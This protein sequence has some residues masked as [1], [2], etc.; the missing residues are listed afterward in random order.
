[1]VAENKNSS[2]ESIIH[3]SSCFKIVKQ[4]IPLL[5]SSTVSTGQQTHFH[6]STPQV[7]YPNSNQ[8]AVKTYVGSTDIDAI[9]RLSNEYDVLSKIQKQR[10]KCLCGADAAA[11]T[12]SFTEDGSNK[13]D[14][15]LD[16]KFTTERSEMKSCIRGTLGRY[17]PTGRIESIYLE[18]IE[19]ISL[20]EWIVRLNKKRISTVN[21]DGEM[22]HDLLERVKIAHAVAKSVAEVHE[23][24]LVH[25]DVT[26][27]NFIVTDEHISATKN[28]YLKVESQ[29]DSYEVNRNTLVEKDEDGESTD[30]ALDDVNIKIINFGYAVE[31]SSM[32]TVD[33]G[34]IV[35]DDIPALAE[36][37]RLLF[38]DSTS[39]EDD[40]EETG[41]NDLGF[42]DSSGLGRNVLSAR[43]PKHTQ[44]SNLPA[45]ILAILQTLPHSVITTSILYEDTNFNSS[46]RQFPSAREVE[47]DFALLLENPDH[48]LFDG[49][50]TS[51]RPSNLLKSKSILGEEVKYREKGVTRNDVLYRSP[52]KLYEIDAE[53]VELL[54]TCAEIFH[55]AGTSSLNND[56]EIRVGPLR[57]SVSAGQRM[58]GRRRNGI[59]LSHFMSTGNICERSAV[60]KP[61]GKQNKIIKKIKN[62]LLVRRQ[63]I[64][65]H[66]V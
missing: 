8:L 27:S 20:K 40:E 12:R 58:F 37:I 16:S 53:S 15:E 9:A 44:L 65:H 42:G 19:G 10:G 2:V 49:T 55:A 52:T 45:S 26:L 62:G 11:T 51:R 33:T 48:F 43:R 36:V 18:Y 4:D 7:S 60:Q 38:S 25:N 14:V 1:M 29:G 41:N 46:F 39:F 61:S 57:R 6:S 50:P 21:V 3:H 22:K 56:Q 30:T 31:Q 13:S 28:E 34:G 32:E 47:V 17:P 66:K 23:L 59:S 24:G 64:H 5:P 63:R 54:D 35:N